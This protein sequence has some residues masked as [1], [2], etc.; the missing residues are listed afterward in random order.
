MFIEADT[1]R[2]CGSGMCALVA[3]ELFDQTE[4][5]GTVIVLRPE[6]PEAAEGAEGLRELAL[7]CERNCPCG[8]ISVRTG[9]PAPGSGA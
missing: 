5:D 9:G 1:G 2:C 4:D 7:E 8:A 6:V 3:G